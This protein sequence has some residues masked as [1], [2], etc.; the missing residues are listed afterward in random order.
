MKTTP[1]QA[2]EQDKTRVR[3]AKESLEYYRR[4]ESDAREALNRA[5]Q[6]TQTIKE[7][8]EAVFAEC[9]ARAVARRKSGQIIVNA[10]Y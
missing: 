8:Y 2:E 7:K 4:A 5:V 1:Q 6:S 3:R 9:E 10:G